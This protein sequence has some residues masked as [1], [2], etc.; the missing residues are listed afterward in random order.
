MSS[1]LLQED[2]D[3]KHVPQTR[4]RSLNVDVPDALLIL[5]LSI[6]SF[7]AAERMPV[8]QLL[9]GLE[10]TAV[11]ALSLCVY[12]TLGLRILFSRWLGVG[13]ADFVMARNRIFTSSPIQLYKIRGILRANRAPALVHKQLAV[14]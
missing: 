2:R 13:G 5:G 7:S 14:E 10:R 11:S 4:K 8:G 1:S 6:Y 12:C 3:A 9:H